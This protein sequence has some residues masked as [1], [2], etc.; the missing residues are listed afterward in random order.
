MRIGVIGLGARILALL[1]EMRELE[2]DV[3]LVAAADINCEAVKAAYEANPIFPGPTR[4]YLD[5]QEMLD[6]EEFDSV[7]IGTICSEHAKYA[8]MVMDKGIYP[9]LEKPLA[10]TFEDLEMLEE[11]L[12]ACGKVGISSMTLRFA[13][14]VKK[15][16]S[17]LDSGIIGEVTQIQAVNNIP[18]GSNFFQRWLRFED[19]TKGLFAQKGMHDMDLIN[20]L[21]D[22]FPVELYAMTSKQYFKG[23]KPAGLKCVDCPENRTCLEGP[24]AKAHIH[25]E[26]TKGDMCC[27]AV[28]TGNEDSSSLIMRYPNGRHAVYTQNCLCKK[29]AAKRGMRFIGTMGTLEFEFFSEKIK[30]WYHYSNEEQVYSF[31]ETLPSYFG[32][33]TGLVWNYYH[34]LLGNEKEI[35]TG[36]DGIAA[37]KLALLARESALSGMPV[38][39]E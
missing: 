9:F 3:E 5:A 37:T 32:G 10:T 23:D 20:Y 18:Y 13:P 24:Y 21:I 14:I 36:A 38:K 27:F 4:F 26:K 28:D 12:K 30:I 25:G 22:D 17:L 16:K 34:T 29:G 31:K 35:A 7:M 19:I 39:V 15:V 6:K 2:F 11:S 33:D 8:K 1:R